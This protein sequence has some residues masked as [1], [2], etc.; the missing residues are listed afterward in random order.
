MS[1]SYS[2]MSPFDPKTDKKNYRDSDGKVITK[3]PNIQTNPP[4]KLNYNRSK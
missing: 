3:Q 4:S 2:Y 1:A